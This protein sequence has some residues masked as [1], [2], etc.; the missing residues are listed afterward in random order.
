[1]TAPTLTR[2]LVRRPAN[3]R[4]GWLLAL[5]VSLAMALSACSGVGG[6]D[7]PSAQPSVAAPSTAPV[8]VAG[9]PRLGAESKVNY[10]TGEDVP[11]GPVLAVKIDNTASAMPQAGVQAA[12]VVYV[13]EVESGV[14]RLLSVFQTEIPGQVGPVRSART[15]DVEILGN[16][17]PVAF[18]VSGGNS[19]VIEQVRESPLQ[20]LSM[21]DGAAGFTREPGRPAVYDVIADGP[22]LL[23]Q[24]PDAATARDIGFRFG[25][26]PAGGQPVAGASYSW[27]SARI[28]FE[29]SPESGTWLQSMGGRPGQAAAG[30]RLAADTVVF[31]A[32]PVVPSQYVDV[33][34]ARSPEVRPVG[35]GAVTVL[36][37]GQAFTGTWSRPSTTDP[38]LFTAADGSE[39]TF[40]PGQTWVVYMEPGDTPVL[41]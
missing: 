7:E 27:P 5:P 10:L 32:V 22:A 41:R 24:V 39:L 16:Y 17:G 23:A 33:T 3:A 38:T 12:D 26:P 31:Q 34:G 25:E 35:E 28:D 19:G 30:G 21:D 8:P 4:T 15:S 13:E 14:T 1:M 37:D 20:L 18:A 40:A 36:R 11:D 6:D 2:R 9:E 29:W